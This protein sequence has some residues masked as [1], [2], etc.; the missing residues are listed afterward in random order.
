[1]DLYK[2]HAPARLGGRISS[3]LDVHLKEGNQQAFEGGASIGLLTSHVLAQGPIGERTS[4]LLAGRASY[5]GIVLLPVYLAYQNDQADAYAN[6]WLY[7]FNGK[8]NHTFADHSR[9]SLSFYTG[10]DHFSTR[11]GNAAIDEDRFNFDWGNQTLTLRYHRLLG[12]KV[13]WQTQATASRYRFR[14]RVRENFRVASTDDTDNEV[15]S[16]TSEPGV[17]NYAWHSRWDIY[18][19]G[20]HRLELGL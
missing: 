13:F 17:Q 11:D 5:L 9:L 20:G 1:M 8:V 16:F 10:Q 12:Q 18:P 4:F 3:V 7:D 6:Y 15:L 2:G 14:Q 19:G